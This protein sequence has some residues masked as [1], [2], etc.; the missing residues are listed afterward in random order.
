MRTL[1]N[2]KQ[3]RQYLA[4]EVKERGSVGLVAQEAGVSVNTVGRGVREVEVGEGSAPG[5]RQRKQGGGRKKAILS[6]WWTAR[7]RN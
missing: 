2:E 1:L 6:F 3:W 7:K 5:D 4:L